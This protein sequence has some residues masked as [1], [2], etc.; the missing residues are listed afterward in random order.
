MLWPS[1]EATGKMSDL[2]TWR[3][4]LSSCL[5]SGVV[6]GSSISALTDPGLENPGCSLC[7]SDAE[8]M[9]AMVLM[10]EQ[11]FGQHSQERTMALSLPICTVCAKRL[12]FG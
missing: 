1:N 5:A 2:A 10:F 8:W 12:M 6:C 7:S 4:A 11:E 3:D 9:T